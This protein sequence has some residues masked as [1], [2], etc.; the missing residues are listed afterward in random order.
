VV[1]GAKFHSW[2]IA[3]RRLVSL[4]ILAA[5]IASLSIASFLQPA[6]LAAQPG[7]TLNVVAGL[8]ERS[9]SW[10]DFLPGSV[11]V[12]VGTTVVWT[13]QSDEVHTVTFLAGQPRPGL[14]VP[15]PEGLDRPPMLEP[16]YAFPTVPPGPWD[17][18]TFL[19]SGDL[20][21]GQPFPVTFARVGRYDYLCLIHPAMTGR[22][23]VVEA[24]AADLTTQADVDRA[25]ASD[26][27]R[28][29]TQSAEI[30]ATRSAPTVLD[31]PDGTRTWFVRAGT[32]RRD[33]RLD[34]LAFLPG[35]VTIR[36]GDSIAWYTDHPIPHTVT[37]PAAGAD[38]PAFVMI[39]LPNGTLLPA[40]ELGQPIPPEI[41]ILLAE[42]GGPPRLVIGPG[43]IPSRP[44]PSYDG[45]SFY[46]SGLMGDHPGML[47]PTEQVWMLT[48][49]RPGVYEY[50]CVLHDPLGME[51]TVTV[52]PR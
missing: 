22:V 15:Q 6:P 1:I 16:A 43:G 39:Q 4:A 21:R 46:N 42:A 44:S 31:R 47:I 13:V 8:G 14:I 51:G 29:E 20:G 32:N 26:R 36:Q 41:G 9:V 52:T 48:F 3:L 18:T 7:P 35:D 40:P 25:V 2:R 30:I 11:R 5:V 17:G 38:E 23:E 27:A 12:P 49:D 33:Q 37:F 10:N 19:N 28:M 24:G 45:Q 50:L 34:I